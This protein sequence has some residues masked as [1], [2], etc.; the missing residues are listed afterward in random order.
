MRGSAAARG[1]TDPRRQDCQKWSPDPAHVFSEVVARRQLAR[2]VPGREPMSL[3]E[4]TDRLF[5]RR[6]FAW[7][8]AGS[9][10]RGDDRTRDP[11]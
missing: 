9:R 4:R 3:A 8:R 6:R 1:S 10:G 2:S 7:R 5:E 11:L